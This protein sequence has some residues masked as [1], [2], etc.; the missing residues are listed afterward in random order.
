MRRQKWDLKYLEKSKYLINRNYYLSGG[1]MKKL[2]VYV[3]GL[4]TN[5]KDEICLQNDFPEYGV[6]DCHIFDYNLW[7]KEKSFLSKVEEQFSRVTNGCENVYLICHSTGGNIGIYLASKFSTVKKL[8]LLAPAVKNFN[9]WQLTMNA[10]QKS[11][12]MPRIDR[13]IHTIKD[14]LNRTKVLCKEFT[15]KIFKTF[16]EI[17]KLA[18]SSLNKCACPTMVVQGTRDLIVPIESSTLVY[19]NIGSS[20]KE[21]IEVECGE[22]R[23][24]HSNRKEIIIEEIVNFLEGEQ[25]VGIA[26]QKVIK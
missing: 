25:E 22:H 4:I 20:I 13:E 10:I 11:V 3:P 21:Y 24:L 17:A 6:T 19:D 23:I 12:L 16:P 15:F 5:P 2:F 18:E 9:L 14:T 7:F 26:K 8:V 1:F